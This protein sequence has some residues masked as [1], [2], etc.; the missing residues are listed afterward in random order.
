MHT[1]E[2][3]LLKTAKK[4]IEKIFR[5]KNTEKV[6]NMN[7]IERRN[8]PNPNKNGELARVE[9]R[10]KKKSRRRQKKRAKQ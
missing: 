6:K 8:K 9:M 5:K 4:K 2:K 3:R 7:G 1:A 10:E